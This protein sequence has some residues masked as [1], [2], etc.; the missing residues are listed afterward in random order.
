MAKRGFFAEI[1]YQ[2]QQAERR[3]RRRGAAGSRK[4]RQFA[5]TTPPFVSTSGP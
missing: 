4:R 5:R 1:N 2:A 3:S